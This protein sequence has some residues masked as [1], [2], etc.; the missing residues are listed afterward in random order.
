MVCGM[1]KRIKNY[2]ISFPEL[3]IYK[4]FA[5]TDSFEEKSLYPGS[6]KY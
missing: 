1:K 3:K 6:L 4:K 2:D 5:F